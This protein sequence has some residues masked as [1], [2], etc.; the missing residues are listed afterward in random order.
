MVSDEQERDGVSVMPWLYH[1]T[2]A[3]KHGN[4]TIK[5]SVCKTVRFSGGTGLQS[6]TYHCQNPRNS[7]HRLR[8]LSSTSCALASTE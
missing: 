6:T 3:T 1:N 8:S 2:S 4:A 5:R 7:S